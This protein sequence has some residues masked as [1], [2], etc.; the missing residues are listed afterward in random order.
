[1][2]LLTAVYSRVAGT[3]HLIVDRH[4]MLLLAAL[5]VTGAGI[6]LL[7]GAVYGVGLPWDSVNYIGVA[8]NLLAGELW[9]EFHGGT[10][11]R[12]GPLYPALLAAPGLLGFDPYAVA[13]PLN[14]FLFG[15]TI[16]VAG[17]WMRQRIASR[18][19]FLWTCLAVTFALPLITFASIALSEPLFILFVVLALFY[20]D[21]FLRGGHGTSLIWAVL[22]TALACLTR[23]IGLTLVITLLPLLL[24][25]PGMRPLEKVKR[26]AV[27]ALI[28]II[29]I[30]L[31]IRH[32]IFRVG[33]PFG[34]KPPSP[35]T[36]SEFLDISFAHLGEWF[37][38]D[39]S[40][41]Y[42]APLAAAMLLALVI[43]IGFASARA[44]RQPALW[45]SWSS[46]CLCGGFILVYFIAVG[47]VSIR[48]EIALWSSRYWIP[49][50][51]PL[52]FA[53]ILLLDRFLIWLRKNPWTGNG[54]RL[55]MIGTFVRGGG[56]G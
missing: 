14:A 7:H 53:L 12:W 21:R 38:P 49:I 35:N 4:C 32:N 15:L 54:V 50:Y 48:V 36:L 24:L 47:A 16:F 22:F 37:L 6:V 23:Y 2:R 46:F 29:P 39:L 34:D 11:A 42:T 9:V 28:S 26:A 51:I 33:S 19:L 56:G 25:Q 52:H 20:A 43:A 40:Q 13:G 5:A 3:I 30:S 27:F 18:L 8:R 41:K 10:Y 45:R 31:W 55:P 1:M 44:S 17:H